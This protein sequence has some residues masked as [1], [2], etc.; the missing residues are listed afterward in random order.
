[1]FYAKG[2]NMVPPVGTEPRTSGFRV[3]CTTI[4]PPSFP[5]QLKTEQIIMGNQGQDKVTS[6]VL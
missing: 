3:L 2:H 5:G 6:T 4:T 1:M